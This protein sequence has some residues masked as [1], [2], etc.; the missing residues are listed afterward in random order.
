M[1]K[2]QHCNA[3]EKYLATLKDQFRIISTVEGH[4]RPDKK[5]TEKKKFT[6]L[7]F[8]VQVVDLL[9]DLYT[10]FD[11]IIDMHD[12]Y[13]VSNRRQMNRSL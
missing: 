13:K 7:A 11:E 8:P 1:W 9:N 10:C 2:A 6:S 12:V 5:L 4:V 3:F